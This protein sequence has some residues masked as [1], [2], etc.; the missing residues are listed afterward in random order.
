ML[1]YPDRQ[2]DKAHRDITQNLFK[3]L[4]DRLQHAQPR[5]FTVLIFLGLRIS[6]HILAGDSD[7]PLALNP[8]VAFCSL[9]GGSPSPNKEATLDSMCSSM[10][11]ELQQFGD[12]VLERFAMD[13][14]GGTRVDVGMSLQRSYCQYRLANPPVNHEETSRHLASRM[15]ADSR[16]AYQGLY[17]M[18]AVSRRDGET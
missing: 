17:E 8:Y 6:A 16:Q 3:A 7:R 13:N 14:M 12:G 5:E 2:F 18:R 1:W 9:I 10:L 15:V 11:A 4:L